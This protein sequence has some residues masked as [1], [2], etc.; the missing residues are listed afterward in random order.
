VRVFV[1][2]VLALFIVSSAIHYFRPALSNRNY[3]YYAVTDE[4]RPVIP[5]GARVLGLPNWYLGLADY[6]Y[7]SSLGL[8]YYHIYNNYSLTEGLE[9]IRPD[10]MIV[11]SALQGLLVDEGY[12]PPGPAFEIYKL[13]RQELEAFLAERGTKVKEFTNPWHGTFEIYKI[14]WDE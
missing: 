9:A 5:P 3:N 8:T 10:Y 2:T 7:R 6:D 13:P 14:R 12:F 4:I 11:D 1:L